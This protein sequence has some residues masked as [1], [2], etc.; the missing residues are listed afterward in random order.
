MED[1]P[2]IS[3]TTDRN[4][5]ERLMSEPHWVSNQGA[6]YVITSVRLMA[7]TP[8]RDEP[9]WSVLCHL[10]RADETCPIAGS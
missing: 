1:D 5:A 10:E 9:M 8:G 2:L 4:L 3:E 6:H 7:D